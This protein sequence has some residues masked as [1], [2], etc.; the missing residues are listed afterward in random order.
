MKKKKWIEWKINIEIDIKEG[1]KNFLTVYLVV[2][3]RIGNPGL[4]P[5]KNGK[6]RD[7]L[8][9]KDLDPDLDH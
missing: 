8:S 2:V 7:R 5:I 1:I 9:G 4:N 3:N 6:N